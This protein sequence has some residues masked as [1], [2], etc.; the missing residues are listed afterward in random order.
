MASKLEPRVHGSHLPA[1]RRPGRIL[2]TTMEES[3][4]SPPDS[5][6]WV[7]SMLRRIEMPPKEIDAV[8]GASD[9]ETV[10]R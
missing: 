7:V 4:S 10:R 2:S 5:M 6:A 9:P 1:R 8:V 3:T